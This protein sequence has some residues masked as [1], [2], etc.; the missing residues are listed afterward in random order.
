MDQQPDYEG[1]VTRTGYRLTSRWLYWS[2]LLAQMLLW[3]GSL[4][5]KSR[6]W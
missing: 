1:H 4:K 2:F 6:D 3:A 5:L